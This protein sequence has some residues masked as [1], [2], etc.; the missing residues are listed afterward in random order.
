VGH[1]IYFRFFT[2][3]LKEIGCL[4]VDEPAERLFN[5][6]MVNDE[7]GR[8]M[9]KRLGNV[10]SPIGLVENSGGDITRLA[11][12]FKGP[13]NV[14]MNWTHD[15]VENMS[16]FV[17]NRFF[18]LI[19]HVSDAP[20]DLKRYFKKADLTLD[21]FRAYVRLN[22]TIKQA[23]QDLER[24][25][26][27]T[28]IAAIMKFINDFEPAKL[29]PKLTNYCVLKLVQLIAPLAPCLAEEMWEIAGR[30]YSIFKSD[31]PKFDPEAIVADTIIIAV[32]VNGKLRGQVEVAA[33]ADKNTVIAAAKEE[34]RV[35]PYI[36]GKTILKEVYVPGRLVNVVVK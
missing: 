26:F 10:V 8:K 31:W 29:N 13:A 9:S 34:R 24:M 35:S 4:A 17:A 7:Q 14:E 21:E 1:L 36:S 6:G 15:M 33:D 22:Q 28:V 2:K 20:L 3:F 32:Q 30:P 11:M 19:N 23:T 18:P 25:Q 16:R 12:F 27:H 5:H